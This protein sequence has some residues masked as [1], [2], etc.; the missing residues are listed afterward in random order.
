M[1]Y[2]LKHKPEKWISPARILGIDHGTKTLGLAI[3]DSNQTIVTPMETIHRKK[4]KHDSHRLNDIIKENDIQAI[5]VGYPLNMDGSAGARC[6]SVKDF[7]MLMEETWDNIPFVFWD[8]RLS[9][10]YVDKF[11]DNYRTKTREKR[12][13]FKDA[14]AAQIILEDALSWVQ[15]NG[16]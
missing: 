16:V 4:W 5:V 6:Q 14:L 10:T 1:A 15:N 11:L 7:V 8:E 3:C 2:H 12:K 13:E 9:T